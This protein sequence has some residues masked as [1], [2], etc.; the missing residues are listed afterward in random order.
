MAQH[1]KPRAN[2]LPFRLKDSKLLKDPKNG[3]HRAKLP[4]AKNRNLCTS[5]HKKKRDKKNTCKKLT[6]TSQLMSTLAKFSVPSK[7]FDFIN[8]HLNLQTSVHQ[9]IC[10]LVPFYSLYSFHVPVTRFFHRICRT[11]TTPRPCF[12]LE[13]WPMVT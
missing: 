5:M 6:E 12:G 8:L 3:T 2:S 13:L 11:W 7:C 9:S 4:I 1:P 10:I